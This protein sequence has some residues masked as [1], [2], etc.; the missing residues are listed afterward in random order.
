MTNISRRQA[1]CGVAALGAGV[2]LLAA[3]GGA[4]SPGDSA[5]PPAAGTLLAKK[6]D[7]PVGSGIVVTEHNVIVTQPKAGTFQA[8][9]NIC[10]HMQCPITAVEGDHVECGCHHSQFSLAD[11]SVL[12]GPATV[13]LPAVAIKVK[14][15]SILTA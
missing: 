13:A 9:S 14:G 1:L 6:A 7:V 12:Q 3:C 11:G 4:G 10:T 5:A 8:Y 2:P 15:D